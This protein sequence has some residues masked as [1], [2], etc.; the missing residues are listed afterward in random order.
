MV[1]LISRCSATPNN[2]RNDREINSIQGETENLTDEENGKEVNDEQSEETERS[3]GK[4][5]SVEE[6]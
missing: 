1:F 4:E 5:E 3:K 6:Q 2:D